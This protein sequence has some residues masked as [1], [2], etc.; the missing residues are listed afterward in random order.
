MSFKTATL[1]I[2]IGM[3]IAA[4]G[5]SAE[6]RSTFNDQNLGMSGHGMFPSGNCFFFGTQQDFDTWGTEAC[7]GYPTVYYPAYHPFNDAIITVGRND[8][9]QIT[10]WQNVVRDENILVLDYADPSGGD[11]VLEGQWVASASVM[12]CH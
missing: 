11:T 10:L 5:A 2:A 12:I 7:G 1:T 4:S 6:C 8:A 3:T 9:G